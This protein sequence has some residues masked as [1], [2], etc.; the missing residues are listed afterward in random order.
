MKIISNNSNGKKDYMR[1]IL[2]NESHDTHI[3]IASAF[4]TNGDLLKYML[5]NNCS[6]DMIVRMSVA[7]SCDELLKFV[8][9]NNVSLRFYTGN[10][11]HPKFYIFGER[12]AYLGSSNFTKKGLGSNQEVNIELDG[13]HPEFVELEEV[14]N[15]YWESAQVLTKEKLLK[16][17]EKIE[18]FSQYD[19][20]KK[21]NEIFG[22]YLFDNV[23]RND[24][25]NQK[26]T[27]L[28]KFEKAYQKYIKAYNILSN[29]YTESSDRKFSQVPVRI[30]IDR[31]LWWVR[32]T[33]AIGDSYKIGYKRTNNEIQMLIKSLKP[34]FIK[35]TNDY[36]INH[37]MQRYVI[38][39]NAFSSTEKIDNYTYEKL[40]DLMLNIHAFHDCFRFYLGGKPEQKRQFLLDNNIDKVKSTLKYLLFD[41]ENYIIKT[42]KCLFDPKYK[43]KHFDKG[44][45]KELYGLMNNQD[46]PI[47]NGRTL[48]SMEWLGFGKL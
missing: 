37:A 46:I 19:Y 26:T 36:L 14:F 21:I 6:V 35:C 45:V 41:K 16:F 30:E 12:I 27:Y 3:K 1:F 31:F 9:H 25:K 47:C 22:E 17:K 48:K 13:E 5:D 29:Y 10:A 4:F 34:D 32:E 8:D 38:L 15:S 39:K 20:T 18:S 24:K 28:D 43:L 42:F 23:N 44:C 2:Q 11:F 33:Q 40:Y 7:T